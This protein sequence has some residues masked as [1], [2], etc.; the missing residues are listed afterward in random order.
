MD[1]PLTFFS[2]FSIQFLL[3]NINFVAFVITSL[4]MVC[5]LGRALARNAFLI[6]YADILNFVTNPLDLSRLI[7]I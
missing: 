6:D 4:F 2:R 5:K 7:G 3:L 1:G